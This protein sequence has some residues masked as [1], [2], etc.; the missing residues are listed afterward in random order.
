MSI[1]QTS[2]ADSPQPPAIDRSSP[3]RTN[4]SEDASTEVV[5]GEIIDEVIKSETTHP[6]VP[7]IVLDAIND[8]IMSDPTDDTSLDDMAPSGVSQVRLQG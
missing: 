3:E 8:I 4:L 5:L 2:T 1:F 6:S 7:A